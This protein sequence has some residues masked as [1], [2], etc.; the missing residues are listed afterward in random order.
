MG[1]G[2]GL[3]GFARREVVLHSDLSQDAC[4][5]WR[6]KA[7]WCR[8]NPG[9]FPLQQPAGNSNWNLYHVGSVPPETL[10]TNCM[11]VSKKWREL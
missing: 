1:T 4:I 2:I 11:E 10:V 7:F 6:H 9:E 8:S 5:I 3:A